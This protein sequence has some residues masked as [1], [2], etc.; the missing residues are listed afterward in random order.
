MNGDDPDPYD[1]FAALMWVIIAAKVRRLD[2]HERTK[3]VG[4]IS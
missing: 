1:D 2:L 3:E 4:G